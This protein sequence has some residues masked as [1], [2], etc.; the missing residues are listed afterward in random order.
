MENLTSVEQD[1][2]ANI[3]KCAVEAIDRFIKNGQPEHATYLMTKMVNLASDHIRLFSGSLVRDV[4][5]KHVYADEGLIESIKLFLNRSEKA[6]LEIAVQKEV[7]GGSEHPIIKSVQ[8]MRD[9]GTLKGVFDIRK[10]D[11][12]DDTNHFMVMD[13]NAYRLELDHDPCNAIANFNDKKTSKQITSFFI[14]KQ[15]R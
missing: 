3:D 15:E 12:D 2:Y 1:Y 4:C 9:N 11:A 7:D 5:D 10:V 8:E 13:D 6:T 14:I